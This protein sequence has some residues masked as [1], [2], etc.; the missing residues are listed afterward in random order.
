MK[1]CIQGTYSID[2][3]P[4]HFNIKQQEQLGFEDMIGNTWLPFCI[5][6][7]DYW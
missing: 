3:F 6:I 1:E 4:S 7:E 5:T 2:P